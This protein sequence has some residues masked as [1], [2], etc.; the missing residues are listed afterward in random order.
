MA[1]QICLTLSLPARGQVGAGVWWCGKDPQAASALC[2]PSLPPSELRSPP[3]K[4]FFGV[5]FHTA[6]MLSSPQTGAGDAPGATTSQ[7]PPRWVPG[8]IF[9][10]ASPPWCL[11]RGCTDS[12][13][14]FGP[15]PPLPPSAVTTPHLSQPH[16]QRSVFAGHAASHQQENV[17][18]F[19]CLCHNKMPCVWCPVRGAPCPVCRS[20]WKNHRFPPISTSGEKPSPAARCASLDRGVLNTSYNGTRL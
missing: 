18:A 14:V 3:E 20:A 17:G 8:W 6:A 19:P 2:L 1:T 13:R 9:P 12:R 11:S 7:C 15:C 10:P 5:I 16:L 4:A